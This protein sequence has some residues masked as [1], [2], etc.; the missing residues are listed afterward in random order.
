MGSFD[1]V[2]RPWLPCVA[3]DGTATELS[4]RQTLLEAR[5]LREVYD[6]SPL[7]TVALHRLLLAI[8]HRAH[9]GP[10]GMEEWRDI[11]RTGRFDQARIDC[12]LDRWRHRFDLFDPVRPFYQ[13]P[14]IPDL[15]DAK[16]QA[17]V[18]KLAQ[19]S[20]AGNNATLFDHSSDEAPQPVAAA[21]AARD[22]VATQAFSIGFGK[23]HPYYLSDST[24][25]RGY[26]VLAAGESL[27]ETL[28]LNL[29]PYNQYEPIPW[30]EDDDLPCWEQELPAIPDREGTPATGYTDY[31]TW[32]SRQIHLISDGEG[33]TVTRCQ[34]RQRL[35][36]AGNPLDPF[37]CYLQ[38]P[39]KGWRPRSFR[40]RRALWRDSSL[41]F[42]QLGTAPGGNVSRRPDVMNWLA[43]IDRE[44]QAKRI[45]AKSVYRLHAFGV[46][47]DDGN[48]ASVVLW[49]REALPLPL[50]VI[51]EPRAVVAVR[52]AIDIAD[53]VNRALGASI[54]RLATLL[55]A[56]TSD[57]ET[58]LQPDSDKSVRPLVHSLGIE[59]R[60]WP[61]LETPFAQFLTALPHD[62]TTDTDGGEDVIFGDATLR[63]WSAAVRSAARQAFEEGT[64]GLDRSARALKAVAVARRQFEHG[65]A[66]AT[67]R[68]KDAEAA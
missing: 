65:L 36:L 60:F 9:M 46:T 62:R 39:L 53:A 68:E 50:A 18:A 57:Q 37:K 41:L 64:A 54:R 45:T 55:L 56:P 7:V 26:S 14:F 47:T 20:A 43:R 5:D 22:L 35:K 63:Q 13:M 61:L 27:F 33:A 42:E 28:A 48:A 31:L 15:A 67:A 38:D 32:Q 12:Y 2:D 40:P 8:L 49:R 1:L 51:D 29:Q 44:R 19:E 66:R 59:G 23:S 21:K 25:I 6:P 10:A 52:E 4:L 24:L 58:S 11:W 16:K 3:R 17:P 30:L 34:V